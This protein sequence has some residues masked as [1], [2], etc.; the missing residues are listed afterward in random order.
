MKRRFISA[1]VVLGERV[2][3]ALLVT[4]AWPA[5]VTVQ[6]QLLFRLSWLADVQLATE[7]QI[8]MK[9]QV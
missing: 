6:Q 3:V 4:R 8:K 7:M 5:R 2:R 1:P 9:G